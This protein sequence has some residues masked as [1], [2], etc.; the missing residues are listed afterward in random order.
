M[1]IKGKFA[2]AVITSL[3][4]L[5]ST[6]QASDL[7]P[8]QYLE[9]TWEKEIFVPMSDGINLSTDVL[10]PKGATGKLPTVLVRTP[11]HKE[12]T[13]YALFKAWDDMFLQRGYAVVIQN[14]RGRH[15]SEGVHENYLE[16]ANTDGYDAVEW[17]VNQPWSNGKVG[18][19]GCSSSGEQQWGMASSNHPGH[20]AALP[21]ASGT[22][23]GDIPGNDT[24][25][26]IY[27]GG[28]P[29]VGLWAW[30]Y[31]DMSPTERLLLPPDTTQ[32]QR[33]RLRNAFTLQPETWFYRMN[34]KTIDTSGIKND[35]LLAVSHLPSKDILRNLG[36]P[37]TPFDQYLT[38]SAGDPRWDDVEQIRDGAKPRVPALH[39]NTWHDIGVGEMTRLFKYLQ[40]M[41]TPNQYLIVGAGPHCVMLGEPGLSDLKFGDLHVGDVRY[42]GM[43]YGFSRL[44]LDWFDHWLK[45]VD[46]GVTEMDPVQ[47]YVMGK[48]WISGDEWPLKSTQ[49]T[50]YFLDS[51]GRAGHRQD[52]GSLS[53]SAAIGPAPDN[54]TYDPGVP[55][56]TRGGGCC[57][58]DMA[59]DQRDIEVRSDV[60]VY[61]TPPLD[62]GVTIAGPIEVVLYVSSSARDTDFTVKLTDVYPDGT[63]INLNDDGFRVRYREGFDRKV[64]MESGKVYKITLGNMVTANHFPAGHRIRLQVSSSNFPNLERNL[65]TGGNNY[66]ETQWVVAENSVHHSRDYPSHVLLPVI[67]E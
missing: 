46:N 29:M 53:T 1:L 51:D 18:T 58:D 20:A 15:F 22:A 28:I 26:A 39:V 40:D 23:V 6:L 32:E 52:S 65:N 2:L 25:G 45:G 55:V 56:P 38:W 57:S 7:P 64:L 19:I 5:S 62:Q 31:H 37:I 42:N 12:N 47:L 3:L 11:Y 59:V 17:V 54:F 49:F 41:E 34:G 16:G 21:L 61:S 63:S 24:Q 67:P 50:R 13:H 27:R 35:P 44:F 48:G 14:E 10:L 36:G 8:P 30:W 43:D 4:S 33:I 60:L 9:W 66:D